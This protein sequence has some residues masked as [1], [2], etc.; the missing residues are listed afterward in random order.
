LFEG[1]VITMDGATG[2]IFDGKVA[3][4]RPELTG[5]F[6]VLM[7]WV[8][9]IRRLKVRANAETALDAETAR[10]FGAEGIGL[11][12]TE[13]MFFDPARILSVREMILAEDETGRRDALAKILPMQR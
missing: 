1:D 5:D 10:K 12:R 6:A 2:E 11:C 3:T 8:D 13:H 7:G 4:I 9:K